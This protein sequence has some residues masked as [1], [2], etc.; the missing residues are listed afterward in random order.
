[1]PLPQPRMA[2][3]ILR[4]GHWLKREGLL[5]RMTMTDFRRCARSSSLGR[6]RQRYPCEKADRL[7]QHRRCR[8]HRRES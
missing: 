6:Y 7:D 8:Y 3:L 2:I 1:M 5:H 4:Q